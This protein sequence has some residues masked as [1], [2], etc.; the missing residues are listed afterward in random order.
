M[1]ILNFKRDIGKV[2]AVLTLSSASLTARAALVEYNYVGTITANS[3]S[4]AGFFS[5]DIGGSLGAFFEAEAEAEAQ[6]EAGGDSAISDGEVD[7]TFGYNGFANRTPTRYALRNLDSSLAYPG[8][9]QGAASGSTLT[10]DGNGNIN[11]GFISLF[12]ATPP[13]SSSGTVHIDVDAGTWEFHLTGVGLAASGTGAFVATN[14]VPV[15]AAAWLFGSAM[16]GLA[17]VRRKRAA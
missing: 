13:E 2:A 16:L 9:A 7:A 5:V 17:G 1:S 8:L 3:G 14:P 11:G 6:A 12:A 10:L 15:P 4:G